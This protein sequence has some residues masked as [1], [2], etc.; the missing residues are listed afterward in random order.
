MGNSQIQSLFDFPHMIDSEDAAR[1]DFLRREIERHNR[2]YYEEAT[3]EISDTEFDRLQH[4]LATIEE[5]HPELAHEDSPTRRVGGRPIEGFSP[6]RHREPM[7]SLD[8]TYS[9][10]EVVAFFQ[11]VAKALGTET[12]P[13]VIEPKVDGVALSL[14][15]E[16]GKLVHA[17]T[18]GDGTVGDNITENIKTIRSIPQSLPEEAPDLLEIRGE[19]F[20][21]RAAFES[22]NNAREAAGLDPFKN[23]RNAAA[24][25]LKQLDPK[26]VA[27]RPL[28]AVFHGFGA[29]SG[30]L[31]PTYSAALGLLT[32]WGFRTSDRLW[33]AS[34]ANGILDAINKL[35]A[36]RSSLPYDTDGAVIKVDSFADRQR[37]GAT[38]KSPRWATAYKFSPEQAET[39]LLDIIIQV[40]RTGVL[41]PVA[42]L[43]PVALSG[44]TVSRATL[45][46][47]EEI[48]RKDIRIGDR[49]VVE[50]AGEIIPAVVRRAG[51]QRSGSERIF[52][53]P[54]TCP[55]CGGAVFKAPGEVAFRCENASCPAQLRRR[56]I[57]FASRGAMDIEGIGD[58]LV[59]QLVDAGLL[60]DIADIYRLKPAELVKLERMGEKSAANLVAAIEASK[61]PPLD[62]FLFALGILHVG[63]SAARTLAEHFRSLDAVAKASPEELRKIPDIGEI[64][65]ASIHGFFQSSAN[66]ELLQRLADNGVQ[67]PPFNAAQRDAALV[68]TTW[69]LTGTLPRSR[70]EVT[71][72]LRN[73]GAKVVASVSSKTT[74]LLAGDD[75]GSKL[76]KARSLGV[77]ILS[78]SDVEELFRKQR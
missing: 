64:V 62:R 52:L 40:G 25:S 7:L 71:E 54:E 38:A 18:R 31:P 2:L 28:D 13:F 56:I 60:K 55:S 46:N 43:E 5:A 14:L 12:V 11:R 33:F 69:V 9:I 17:A 21:P 34:D 20:L 73:L 16:S 49:V 74:H 32:R 57:H 42:I 8:N 63:K 1:A 10:G 45:H 76:D 35:D 36:F 41:T 6:T 59:N 37:L 4:E 30:A 23:P 72:Y 65:A 66:R 48:H 47:Q 51:G 3:P 26:E 75:A 19:I 27:K 78:W 29:I 22:I 24:G 68:G 15:F 67:P 53:M 58:A 61:T 44:S 50:K 39:R 77:R 70:E